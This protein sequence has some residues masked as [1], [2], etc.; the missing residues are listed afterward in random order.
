MTRGTTRSDRLVSAFVGLLLLAAGV[1][2]VLWSLDVVP[3]LSADR[4]AVAGAQ[5]LADAAWWP[6]ALLVGGAVLALAALAWCLAHLRRAGLRTIALEGSGPEGRL[7]VR[8]DAVAAAAAA[9]AE[10]RIGLE[11]ASGH[12]GHGPEAGLVEVAVTAR[13]DA[14]LEEVRRDLAEVDAEVATATAGAVPVRYR[15]T[16][17]RPPRDAAPS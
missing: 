13:H 10:R 5:D 8:L 6:W 14:T 11:S 3:A 9:S 17:A 12:T 2:A 1:L 4:V 7:R 16:V 15:V